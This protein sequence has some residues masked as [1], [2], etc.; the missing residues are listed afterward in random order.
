MTGKLVRAGVTLAFATLAAAGAAVPALSVGTGSAPPPKPGAKFSGT[1]SGPET[2]VRAGSISFRVSLGGRKI[3]KLK[4][5]GFLSATCEPGEFRS[6]IR[7]SGTG[8]L[9]PRS[10][11]ITGGRFS[12]DS[13]G[14]HLKGAFGSPTRA[15]GTV[16]LDAKALNI[17]TP[18]PC[19]TG[20][21]R[22]AAQTH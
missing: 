17:D 19:S 13:A 18:E 16:I 15:T 4:V 6:L 21:L 2:R 5:D 11:W 3:E 10:L 14:W 9:F 1:I 7:Q 12:T 8:W 20:T 22:W